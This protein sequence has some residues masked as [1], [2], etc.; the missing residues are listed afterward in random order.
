MTRCNKELH[1]RGA[2]FEK[3]FSGAFTLHLYTYT[4]PS[5]SSF[6]LLTATSVFHLTALI[7]SI[8]C[9]YLQTSTTTLLTTTTCISNSSS[10]LSSQSEQSL[11]CLASP[12]TRNSARPNYSPALHNPSATTAG[13]PPHPKAAEPSST[14]MESDKA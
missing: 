14:Q 3:I 10:S 11:P 12:P 13:H 9:H 7:L 4:A 6:S 5:A 2:F 1:G 8:H